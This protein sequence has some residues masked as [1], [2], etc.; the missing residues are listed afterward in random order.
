M[1][2]EKNVLSTG[3]VY[4]QPEVIRRF[5][6]SAEI[7]DVPA[8]REGFSRGAGESPVAIVGAR[9]GMLIAMYQPIEC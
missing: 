1:G 6:Q 9:A 2:R 8:K 4:S 3:S 7:V 5:V